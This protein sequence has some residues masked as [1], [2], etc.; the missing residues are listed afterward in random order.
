MW[1][2]RNLHCLKIY[3]QSKTTVELKWAND[4]EYAKM[5]IQRNEKKKTQTTYVTWATQELSFSVF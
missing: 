1:T 3:I 5:C 2:V 4:N